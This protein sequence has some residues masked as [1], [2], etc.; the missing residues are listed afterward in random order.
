MNLT[1]DIDALYNQ[2]FQHHQEGRLEDAKRVY[3]ELLELQPEL[4]Q[5]LNLLGFA[6]YQAGNIQEA[7][8]LAQKATQVKPDEALFLFNLGLYHQRT[9]DYDASIAAF[10]RAIALNPEFGE[11]Y[12]LLGTS[13][14][15]INQPQ[16]AL[17]SYLK[18]AQLSTETDLALLYT[19]GVLA[20]ELGQHQTALDYLQRIPSSHSP[21]YL[22]AMHYM[23]LIHRRLG[24]REQA[25]QCYQ[26]L[27]E[28]NPDYREAFNNYANLLSDLNQLDAACL[29]YQKALEQNP[30]DAIAWD[31]LGL[32]HHK[33]KNLAQ[34]VACFE[35]ALALDSQNPQ[36][37]YNLGNVFTAQGQYEAAKVCFQKTLSLDPQYHKALSGLGSLCFIIGQT[38]EAGV[39]YE[40]YLKHV[41]NDR[42][43]LINLGLINQQRNRNR[44]AVELYL[45]ALEIDPG[46]AV[47][48]DRLGCA[49]YRLGRI[50]DAV[51]SHLKAIEVDSTLA[52]A[53]NNLARVYLSQGNADDALACYQK[54]YELTPKDAIRV[55]M[56]MTMPH[57]FD[58][59]EQLR[60]WRTRYENSLDALAETP[61]VLKDPAIEIGATNFF[62]AHQ[63]FNDKTLQ[64]KFA[65]LFPAQFQYPLKPYQ[66]GKIKIGFISRFL[67]LDHTI[68]KLMFGMID[69]LDRQRFDVTVFTVNSAQPPALKQPHRQIEIPV[70][71]L[72]LACDKVAQSQVDLL[73][74]AD[75]GMDP[76][77]LFMSMERLAPVQ[78]VTWGHP[79]TTGSPN[80][81]YFL[82]S[83]L[84]ETPEAQD[85][86]SEKLVLFQN[87]PTYYA[88]PEKVYVQKQKADFGLSPDENIYLCPQALFKLHPD[89]DELIGGILRQ[90]PK[91]RL[92][93]VE[94]PALHKQ[95]CEAPLVNR[96]RRTLPDVM[97][98]ITFISRLPH[99]AFLQLM[100][101][102]DLLLD[103]PH[104][105]GGNTT[106]EAF[107]MGKPIV[108]CPSALMRSRVTLGCYT[109][110]GVMDCV[111]KTAGEYVDI[112]VK[113]GTDSAYR[114]QLG[115]TIQRQSKVLFEDAHFIKELEAFFV[116]AVEQSANRF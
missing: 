110:M 5:A 94:A 15:K 38:D 98:R 45:K 58:T 27:F 64:E 51:N 65:R 102:A 36:I 3:L 109:K 61:L 112:A 101:V 90:D 63:G 42:K 82:S 37:H 76:H 92:I 106:Y 59:M 111:A 93:L 67:N 104:F 13:L 35:K 52:S 62:V 34:A 7:I 55:K 43:G 16:Q 26:Q 4:P 79:V 74:Y 11:A 100:G 73:F 66:G 113:I 83:A 24:H 31:N 48:Y 20:F 1:V 47:A 28:M 46:D 57:F 105:G 116:S 39:Y 114:E 30:D 25:L 71:S 69:Q 103:T 2:A 107:A 86:Y 12:K 19:V 95:C 68:G 80:M 10:E 87:L 89:F 115:N 18:A 60:H 97:E 81:D 56:A 88:Q 29:Y 53:Y 32:A 44:K 72:K 50:E 85:H 14:Q 17:A 70:N 96:F 6:H 77:T 75:V 41:P 91:G 9:R 33:N 49:Y 8:A 78:C 21:R 40:Q 108:T 54:T 23:G 84:L 22:K 99:H